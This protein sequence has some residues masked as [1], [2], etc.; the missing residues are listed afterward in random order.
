MAVTR[1]LNRARGQAV[2][3]SGAVEVNTGGWGSVTVEGTR[4]STR[5]R[6]PATFLL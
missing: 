4:V 6:S 1:K 3:A 2:T 5:L